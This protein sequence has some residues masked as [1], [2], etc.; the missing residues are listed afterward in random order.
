[1][2]HATLAPH[3][4]PDHRQPALRQLFLDVG[5]P[6]GRAPGERLLRTTQSLTWLGRMTVH[7]ERARLAVPTR[8]TAV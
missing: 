1:M 4:A 5:L 8:G 7:V 3:A 2:V 6:R